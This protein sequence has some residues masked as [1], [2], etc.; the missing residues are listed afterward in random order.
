MGYFDKFK[1]EGIPF[2]ENREKGNMQDILDEPLHI[3]GFG[4][5]KG[6]NGDFACI[7]LSEYPDKFYFANSIITDMLKEVQ[8]DGM[9]EELMYQPIVFSMRTSKDGNDYM[10]FTFES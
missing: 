4:F 3:N 5:I 2:M 9:E 6:K 1:H 8:K 7:S 10:T